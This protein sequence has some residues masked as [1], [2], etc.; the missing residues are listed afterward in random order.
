GLPGMSIPCG[1]DAKGLPV[2]LQ[3]IGN[4]FAEAKMLG[5]A[6]QYQ[7]AT[8]WHMKAPPGIDLN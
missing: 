4:Y 1:F 2:G 8:D 6:H 3:I 7:S 5:I